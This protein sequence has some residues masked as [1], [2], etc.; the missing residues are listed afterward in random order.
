MIVKA[1]QITSASPT[2]L[3][4]PGWPGGIAP[5]PLLPGENG[6]E[7]ADFT[8]K[9]L[10]AAKPRD[11]IE[12]ILARDAI[13]LSWEILR[14][15]RLKAGLL[16]M[17]S[18]AAVRRVAERFSFEARQQI[19]WLGASA[20]KWTD[21]DAAARK[22]FEK[23]LETAGLSMDDVMAEALSKTIDTSGA[24]LTACACKRGRRV[25]TTP[26]ARLIVTAQ[27][28]VPQCGK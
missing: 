16:R 19:G 10:A 2:S 12:E 5:A 20:D 28:S 11:F 18:S 15:R 23:L 1:P 14:Y 25:A 8:S 6:A 9:F 4:A 21:G 27:H 26:Y 7:Y 22:R 3:D 13:D 24:A 17:A